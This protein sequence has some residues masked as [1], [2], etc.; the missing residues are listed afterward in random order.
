MN[1]LHLRV[2]REIVHAGSISAAAEILGYTQPSVSRH[3]AALERETGHRLLTR[4]VTGVELTPAGRT[5]LGHA[6][7]ILTRVD[8]AQTELDLNNGVEDTVLTLAVFEAAVTTFVPPAVQAMHRRAPDV[9]TVLQLCSPLSMP[10][11]ALSGAVDVAVG[12]IQPD[13][14]EPAVRSPQVTVTP[15]FDDELLCVIPRRHPLARLDSVSISQL[16]DEHWVLSVSDQCPLCREFTRVCAAYGFNP[17]RAYQVDDMPA[18]LGIVASGAAFA[19]VPG[20]M[21]D[22]EITG[23]SFLRFDPPIRTTVAAYARRGAIDSPTSILVEELVR[24]GSGITDTI[25]E[26]VRQAVGSVISFQQPAVAAHG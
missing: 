26:P 23:V 4:T 8:M 15:L 22:P 11:L 9:R 2:L 18:T 19:V 5:L 13:G 16:A 12:L 20:L 24:A 1:I 3:L 17:K 14:H 21:L 7:A 6:E 10:S 25:I